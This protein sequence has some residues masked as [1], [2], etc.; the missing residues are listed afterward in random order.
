MLLQSIAQ[1][2]QFLTLRRRSLGRGAETAA[3]GAPRPRHTWQPAKL[4]P[5]VGDRETHNRNRQQGPI[6]HHGIPLSAGAES[7]A[8]HLA[9]D[10]INRL[11]IGATTRRPAFAVDLYWGVRDA[12][13]WKHSL[14]PWYLP[15]G[16]GHHAAL[17]FS[18][19]PPLH[20]CPAGGR[21]TLGG[22]PGAGELPAQCPAPA[23][24][25]SC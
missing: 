8:N 18:F 9:P 1:M 24:R 3:V 17:R 25:R 19:T 10:P 6:D 11:F 13:I 7:A 14:T 16:S 22:R 5:G 23:S 20:G 12:G 21:A 2:Q 15:G 4:R